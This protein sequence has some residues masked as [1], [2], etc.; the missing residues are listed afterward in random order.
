VPSSW[1]AKAILG[2][3]NHQEL[4]TKVPKDVQGVQVEQGFV[5]FRCT[6][7]P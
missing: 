5:L 2:K 4:E 6:N 3:N 1:I 7:R